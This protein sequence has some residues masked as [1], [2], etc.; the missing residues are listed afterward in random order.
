MEVVKPDRS[1]L[2]AEALAGSDSIQQALSFNA[3]LG[4]GRR[5]DGFIVSKCDSVG[6]MV[7]CIGTHEGQEP[8]IRNIA[9]ALQVG[10]LVNMA[11]TTSIP[12]L[13]LGTGQ[14]YGDLRA[15]NV[16]WVCDLLLL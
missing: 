6:N 8:R 12:I 1:L 4:K 3:S 7:C 13:F 11:H 16:D 14:S 9:Y 2:V 10:T 5:L 15:M